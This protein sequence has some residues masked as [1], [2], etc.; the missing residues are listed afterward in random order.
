MNHQQTL[1]IRTLCTAFRQLVGTA[2]I[3]DLITA[4]LSAESDERLSGPETD[5]AETFFEVLCE[6]Y[7]EAMAIA[8]G[9][10]A[11]DDG[12]DILRSLAAFD[13]SGDVLP[14][15]QRAQECINV[16]NPPAR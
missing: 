10:E 8:Q 13:P 11:V 6:L 12:W 1:A 14:L 2:L 5:A 9:F 15:V 3:A 7:P 4:T 16:N